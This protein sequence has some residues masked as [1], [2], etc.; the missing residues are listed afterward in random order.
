VKKLQ[1][2]TFFKNSSKKIDFDKFMAY[3]GMKDNLEKP[4]TWHCWANFIN[5]YN[6]AIKLNKLK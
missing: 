4:L 2:G 6:T 1:S 3:I 5:G